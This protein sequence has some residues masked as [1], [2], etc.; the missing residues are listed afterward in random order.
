ML[1]TRR[2]PI[3]PHHPNAGQ[4]RAVF[5]PFAHVRRWSR[6]AAVWLPSAA[7]YLL[8]LAAI[9]LTSPWAWPPLILLTS[10]AAALLFILAHDAA[11]DVLTPSRWANQL[12]ARL[13][14]LPAWHPYTGWVHAHNH[15]HHGWTNFQPRDYVWAP[16]SLAEYQRLSPVGQAWVRLCRYWPGFGLYYLVEILWKKIW[17]IQPEVKRRKARLRWLADDLLL[18]VML[19][20]QGW[21]LVVLARYWQTPAPAWAIILAAQVLPMFFCNWFVALI[22]YLQ[23]THP[24]IPWFQKSAEWSFYLG[25]VRGTTH[26]HFPRGINGWIHNVMEHTAHHVDPRIPLY[27]L[28]EAQENLD[29]THHPVKHVF[30]WRSFSYTQR[31]CQ[32]YDFENH[33][34]LSFGGEPTSSRTVELPLVLAKSSFT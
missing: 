25:Q 14:F 30:T 15:V 34:W 24:A 21:G 8:S 19:L 28:P 29:A 6:A 27:N 20:A 17:L 32:L 22:T 3:N 2:T 13:S 5:P 26:T 33:C 4:V 7:F 11:H 1:F 12:L 23:H 10:L 31:V 16:L 18:V 9:L